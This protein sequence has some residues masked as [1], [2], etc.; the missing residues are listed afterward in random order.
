LQRER[1]EW[2]GQAGNQLATKGHIRRRLP[3]GQAL[4][5]RKGTKKEDFS[6]VFFVFLCGNGV[7]ALL[8]CPPLAKAGAIELTQV[9]DFQESLR[10]FEKVSDISDDFLEDRQGETARKAGRS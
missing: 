4:A 5:D 6:F 8:F 3:S 9:V 7:L 1:E 10:K 2:P